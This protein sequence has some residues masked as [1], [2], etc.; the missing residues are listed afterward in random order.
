M[1]PAPARP[2]LRR[3]R[4]YADTLRHT[5]PEQLGHRLRLRLLRAWP[6]AALWQERPNGAGPARAPDPALPP[7][8]RDSQATGEAL[9]R[10]AEVLAGRFTFLNRTIVYPERIRWDEPRAERLWRFH[11]HYFAYAADLGAAYAAQADPRYWA[12]CRALLGDWIAA[13]PP[14]RGDGWHPFTVSMRVV[15][16]VRACQDFAG[17]L[18]FESAFRARLTASLRGQAR[19]LAAALERD[20]TGNHL[21]KNGKALLFAGAFLGG[22][23][24]SRWASLGQRLLAGEARAQILEDGGHYERSPLYHAEV[25][26]DYLD[27]APLLRA[28][29]EDAQAVRHA[30]GA[31]AEFLAGIVHPDGTLPLFNDAEVRPSIPVDALLRRAGQDL[32]PAGEAVRAFPASGYYVLRAGDHVLV[33]DCGRVCP[34]HLPAHAHCDLL[35]FELSCGGVR[36]ITNSGT[37]T[38]E[39]GRWRDAF[40]G[41]ASHNTVQADDEEQSAIW[42]AFRVGRRAQVLEAVA[43]PTA[44]G[45]YFRGAYAGFEGNRTRHTRE[46]TVLPDPCWV[47]VDTVERPARAPSLL[48][49]RLHVAPRTTLLPDGDRFVAARE[50]AAVAVV[51]LGAETARVEDAW[52]SPSLGRREP[53][54]RLVLTTACRGMRRLAFVLAPPAVPLAVERFEGAGPTW[55]LRLVVRGRQVDLG[56]VP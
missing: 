22:R 52:F 37:Y 31:M 2:A 6:L 14:A 27:V 34:E 4:L 28:G 43:R 48:H 38:Y 51:P 45:A 10:A 30:A 46:V 20:L 7:I 15:N 53:T 17:P 55:R 23:D 26:A 33:V 25:L 54:Q 3:I 1:I 18:A 42:N 11:L 44:G 9:L 13:N 32:R 56:T 50:G 12:R 29:S 16:W 47:I 41:T 36:L 40:R 35:S 5:R 21:I 49:S 19:Y 39:A 24:G 8:A